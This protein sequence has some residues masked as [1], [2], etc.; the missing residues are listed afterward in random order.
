MAISPIT[1]VND[2]VTK[3]KK[4]SKRNVNGSPDAASV[5]D[6]EQATEPLEGALVIGAAEAKKSKRHRVP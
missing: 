2:D 3:L 6:T 1:V 5:G 4:K